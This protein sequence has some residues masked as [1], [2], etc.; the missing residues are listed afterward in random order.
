MTAY[1]VIPLL[2]VLEKSIRVNAERAAEMPAKIQ[3]NAVDMMTH[4]AQSNVPM[5]DT[6]QA[7][8]SAFA[9]TRNEMVVLDYTP[10]QTVLAPA[11]RVFK[12]EAKIV[13]MNPADSFVANAFRV[14]EKPVFISVPDEAI[15]R[16]VPNN[17]GKVIQM[18]EWT[19]RHVA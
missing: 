19:R 5:V 9:E 14:S 7:L 11:M 15:A 3:V 18:S 12:E 16:A 13:Q 8:R 17:K 1:F 10:K 4:V 2:E 6:R